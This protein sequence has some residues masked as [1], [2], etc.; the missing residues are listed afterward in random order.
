MTI[1]LQKGAKIPKSIL[2]AAQSQKVDLVLNLQEGLTWVISGANIQAPQTVDMA[3]TVKQDMIPS[4]LLA[5]FGGQKQTQQFSL[6]HDGDFG[7]NAQL[8]VTIGAAEEGDYANLYYYNETESCLELIGSYPVKNGV[9]ELQF[10]H[11]S[12]Y[13]LTLGAPLTQQIIT[14]QSAAQPEPDAPAAQQPV[15]PEAEGINVQ[16]LLVVLAVAALAV[17]GLVVLY[18]K[19]KKASQ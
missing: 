15:T 19:R 7:F 13:V 16:M 3:L 4:E 12:G 6:A 11:A 17:T 5:A 18:I 14:R 2:Q 10:T 9:A 1:E 8:N